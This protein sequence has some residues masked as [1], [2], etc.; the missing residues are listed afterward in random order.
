M[1]D[2]NSLEMGIGHSAT[3]GPAPS[4]QPKGYFVKQ[5]RNAS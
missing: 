2:N 3:G 4:Q 5:Y 1:S